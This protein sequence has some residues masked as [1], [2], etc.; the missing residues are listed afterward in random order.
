MNNPE[1]IQPRPVSSVRTRVVFSIGM[2]CLL[3]GIA[4]IGQAARSSY[5]AER[6]HKLLYGDRAEISVVTASYGLNCRDFPVPTG[7]PKR[8][9]QGN[10]TAVMKR[11]CDGRELCNY[12]VDVNVIG[13]PANGCGKEFAV[14]YI[15]TGSSTR[16]T[17]TILAEANGKWV[18]LTCAGVNAPG[19][20]AAAIDRNT[21][22]NQPTSDTTPPNGRGSPA[23]AED[24]YSAIT[25]V[26][27]S[28]GVNCRDFPVPTG[29]PKL[30]DLGNVTEA[31]KRA[32]DDRSVCNFVIDHTK[33]GDPAH[34]CPK[35]FSVDYLC[36]GSKTLKTA[37]VAAEADNKTIVL[38][39]KAER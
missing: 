29:F 12:L 15:C 21:K 5:V 19:P 36:P 22:V 3:I 35:D 26:T 34:G 33:I 1:S 17:A 39:C 27:A 23:E 9:D 6:L 14:D 13:D 37:T 4:V 8:T 32:C 31:L 11:Y 7:L 38:A 25:V 16:W 30:T 10:E 20:G 2:I 18:T 28:Y 24:T